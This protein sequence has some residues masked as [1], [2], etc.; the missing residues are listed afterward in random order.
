[1]IGVDAIV[2]YF[3]SLTRNWC[4]RTEATSIFQYLHKFLINSEN[5]HWKCMTLMRWTSPGTE[6]R[7]VGTRGSLTN[8]CVQ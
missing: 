2:A 4:R 6:E 7:S 8:N 3:R 1:V 5:H